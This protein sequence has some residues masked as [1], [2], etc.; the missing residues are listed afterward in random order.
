VVG[1]N[2]QGLMTSLPKWAFAK[3]EDA[4]KFVKE[5]GGKISSFDE[6]MKAAEDEVAQSGKMSH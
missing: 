6:T 1:G 2:K 5:N 4:Q 3:G